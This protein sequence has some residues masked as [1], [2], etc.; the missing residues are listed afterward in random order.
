[1]ASKSEDL[2]HDVLSEPKLLHSF[3]SYLRQIHAHENLLFIEA[4]SQMR[5]DNS[6]TNF[7]V[8]LNR[9]G[10]GES[11]CG[12][13]F[14]MLKFHVPWSLLEFTNRSFPTMPI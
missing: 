10:E 1:M 3:E 11:E 8:A 12:N 7:E 5:Y 4:I 2:L 14:Q 9:Y 13:V 6:F